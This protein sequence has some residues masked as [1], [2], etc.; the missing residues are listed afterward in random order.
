[1]NI[2]AGFRNIMLAVWNMFNNTVIFPAGVVGNSNN[3]TLLNILMLGLGA[4]FSVKFVRY[5]L[6][7]HFNVSNDNDKGD[8]IKSKLKKK[9]DINEFMHDTDYSDTLAYFDLMAKNG[10]MGANSIPHDK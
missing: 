8:K 4:M 9:D 10:R 5:C 6:G 1:M 3:I 2:G 7:G